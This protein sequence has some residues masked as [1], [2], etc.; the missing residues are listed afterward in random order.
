MQGELKQVADLALFA[1]IVQSGGISRCAADLGLERTTI[2]R[3]LGSLERSLGVRLLDRTPKNIVVTDAGRRCLE[4]CEALLESAHNAQTLATVGALVTDSAPIVVGAPSDM[5]ERYLEPKLRAFEES[6][7]GSKIERRPVSCWTED[8][9]DGIDLGVALGPVKAANVWTHTVG[10][11]RQSVFAS[12]DYIDRHEII[13]SPFDFAKHDC[14]VEAAD[15]NRHSWQFGSN[16]KL[17]T[18]SISPKYTVPNLLE[19]REATLAGLGI[20]RLPYYLCEPYLQAGRLVDLVPDMETD[21]RDVVVI[22]PRQR[23]PKAGTTALRMHLET[24][25]D[26]LAH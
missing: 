11:V 9:L 26:S 2:S 21:G 4:Q 12:H 17:T 14:V 13:R 18:V 19:A 1:K 25:F 16:N 3:R 23:K 7:P 8:S 10:V 5:I 20:S 22:S 24:A 6:H 15:S